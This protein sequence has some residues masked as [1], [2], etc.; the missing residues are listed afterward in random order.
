M[1]GGLDRYCVAC[2]RGESD[3]IRDCGVGNGCAVIGYA[4]RSLVLSIAGSEQ[5]RAGENNG[6]G[7]ILNG[8]H[9]FEF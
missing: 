6:R 3:I 9:R 7:C 2:C 8:L 5:F 4:G 1:C